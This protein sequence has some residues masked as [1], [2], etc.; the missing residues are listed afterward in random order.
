LI[1]KLI[2]IFNKIKIFGLPNKFLRKKN[3][4]FILI[5]SIP[6][7]GTHLLENILCSYKDIYRPLV[8]TLNKNNI[9]KLGPLNNL[10]KKKYYGN[11]FLSHLSYEDYSKYLINRKNVKIIFLIRH[12]GAILIANIYYI[13]KEKKHK[14]HNRFKNLDI[15]KCIDMVLNEKK[16]N[17]FYKNI[18]SF[19]KW[20]NH[21]DILTIRYED[22]IDSK[23]Y[24]K[25][26]FFKN[27]FEFINIT[28]DGDF[29]NK[30]FEN[31]FKSSLTYR[32]KTKDWIEELNYEQLI[33]FKDIYKDILKIYGYSN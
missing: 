28:V 18:L 7:S 1:N 6:K 5:N 13:K 23:L 31:D 14:F 2:K 30:I 27:L 11:L 26:N 21:K 33:K 4:N 8:K 3:N 10:F 9:Y 22:I 29:V 15:P 20:L 12:P 16:E 19:N 17:I 24:K 32:K 25:D